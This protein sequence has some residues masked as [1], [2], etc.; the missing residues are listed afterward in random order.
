MATI[1]NI[2]CQV[3]NL[4]AGQS[5]SRLSPS[6]SPLVTLEKE[7]DFVVGMTG[8]PQHAARREETVMEMDLSWNFE[9]QNTLLHVRWT[10]CPL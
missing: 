1:N 9:K 2:I 6:S 10:P 4:G 5:H 8:H 7:A 3:G